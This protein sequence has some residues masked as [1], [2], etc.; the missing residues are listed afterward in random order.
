[1]PPV[2]LAKDEHHPDYR[3]LPA[4][5]LGLRLL[6]SALVLEGEDHSFPPDD[7]RIFLPVA[8]EV[9]DLIP[10]QS[11]YRDVPSVVRNAAIRHSTLA[12]QP[13]LD[14]AER[15]EAIAMAGLKIGVAVAY[16]LMRA[17]GGA[18]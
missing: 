9:L 1:M 18:R 12:D 7:A 15:D 11:E 4:S 3:H 13:E 6:Y 8:D 17:V 5:D 2:T 14:G 10:Q 16:R